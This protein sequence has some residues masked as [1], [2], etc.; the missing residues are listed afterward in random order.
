MSKTSEA[1]EKINETR[2]VIRGMP[3]E[4]GKISE[5]LFNEALALLVAAEAEQADKDKQ[6]AD[7]RVF[8]ADANIG[9]SVALENNEKLR[10]QIA[11]LN[12]KYDKSCVAYS[13]AC[14]QIA[15]LKAENERLK[16]ENEI[17]HTAMFSPHS[18][19]GHQKIIE[20]NAAKVQ[21]END[22]VVERKRFHK[23]IADL[24]KSLSEA[25]REISKWSREAG[26]QMAENERLKNESKGKL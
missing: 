18:N 3:Y 6:I 11:D 16:K 15:D 19:Y 9:R 25:I 8:L 13:T 22:F 2:K 12:A 1:I 20:V 14:Q 5:Q 10:Q 26:L 17:Y 21:E 24:D 4:W 23:R 7:L